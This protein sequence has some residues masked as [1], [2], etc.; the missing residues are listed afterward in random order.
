MVETEGTEFNIASAGSHGTNSCGSSLQKLRVGC[1]TAE[2]K[3]PLFTDLHPLTTGRSVLV[4][5]ITA[6][7]HV[8]YVGWTLTP[9][10]VI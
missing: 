9:M 8:G 7:S 10:E 4:R 5:A 2:L 1:W 3:L 6:D